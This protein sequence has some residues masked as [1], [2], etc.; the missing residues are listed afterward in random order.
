M[1][2]DGF[3]KIG[4]GG[5]GTVYQAWEISTREVFAVKRLPKRASLEDRKRFG[6]EVRIQV[7]LK[8][9][10]IMP[11]VDY[12]LDEDPP[13]LAMPIASHNLLAVIP[14]LP[15]DEQRIKKIFLQTLQGVRYAH[16]KGIAHRD[17]KPE[18][19]MLFNNDEVRIAD[20]G[21]GKRMKAKTLTTTLTLTGDFLGTLA[22]APPEQIADA[23]Q[24][25]ERA[26][27]YALGKILY[28]MITGT[29]PFPT[30][31]LSFLPPRYR[32]IVSKCLY[33]NPRLRYQSVDELIVD[34]ERV[35]KA[36]GS[37]FETVHER[38]IDKFNGLLEVEPSEKSIDQIHRLLM[39]NVENEEFW[40]EC[41]PRLNGQHLS[42]YVRLNQT[43]FIDS[44]GQYEKH[45]EGNL[46]FSYCDRVANFYSEIFQIVRETSVEAIV[47]T[48]LLR[49]GV[50][51]NRYYVMDTFCRLLTS[52][53][54]Q[55][56]AFVA[57]E[58]IR[59]NPGEVQVMQASLKNL[60]LLEII[61]K[62][63]EEIT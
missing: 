13:W 48:R 47:L 3:K 36:E 44:L 22:Y 52:I 21:L 24:A 54:D 37:E 29:M 18:N 30:Y 42:E 10:N 16:I 51:H 6:R 11:V 31:D 46:P 5:F 26:D 63:I 39:E 56:T 58:V 23:K 50:S 4:S 27:I 49:I 34:F 38:L 40:V 14:Q 28:H 15:G 32:Y 45:I 7:G 2:F 19:I 62:A 8:H 59:N 25:D 55:S 43:G 1:K 57:V 53:R 35:T 12:S 20:F 61:S 33:T 41:F 17:L 9:Q 60:S